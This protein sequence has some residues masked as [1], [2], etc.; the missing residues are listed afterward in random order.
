MEK[1]QGLLVDLYVNVRKIRTK[2]DKHD[3]EE[4][5]LKQKRKAP[6]QGRKDEMIIL[7]PGLLKE[8]IQE[9]S[10]EYCLGY[11]GDERHRDDCYHG[12]A[13]KFLMH[14][15]PIIVADVLCI[16]NIWRRIEP[17]EKSKPH[18]MELLKCLEDFV[19]NGYSKEQ[20]IC[21]KIL[22]LMIIG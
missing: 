12:N 2:L 14:H 19:T 13:I 15:F 11:K 16:N 4:Q 21:R 10:M 17:L 9:K 18:G 22:L 6:Y 8:K 20:L 1:Q 5:Q 3:M 7:W